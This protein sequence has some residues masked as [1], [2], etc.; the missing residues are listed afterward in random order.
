MGVCVSEWRARGGIR[1]HCLL[2]LQLLGLVLVCTHTYTPTHDHQRLQRPSLTSMT[3]VCQND[4]SARGVHAGQAN[5]MTKTK[6]GRHSES[7]IRANPWGQKPVR[8]NITI[9]LTNG[10]TVHY[11]TLTANRT[12]A[13]N[14]VLIFFKDI[15]PMLLLLRLVLDI[16]PL[17]LL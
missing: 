4:Q 10:L 2:K 1:A 14:W 15:R 9:Q 7:F 3:A 8:I 11:E 5:R 17:K 13:W 6:T 16:I 12:D